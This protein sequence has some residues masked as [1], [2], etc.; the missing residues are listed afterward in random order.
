MP[1]PP[2]WH[3]TWGHRR[4]GTEA[5]AGT[6]GGTERVRGEVV[7]AVGAQRSW[8][9]FR[10]LGFLSCLPENVVRVLSLWA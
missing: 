6:Y 1:P 2:P 5:F 7:V 10:R 3:S 9:P 4:T 8:W